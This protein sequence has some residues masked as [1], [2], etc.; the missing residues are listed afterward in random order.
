VSAKGCLNAQTA[1][2]QVKQHAPFAQAEAVD[3]KCVSASA[4]S[5]YGQRG[6][7]HE[8]GEA[9]RRLAGQ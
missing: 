7:D 9:G 5:M 1:Q 6:T 3:A 2:E 8:D 4:G